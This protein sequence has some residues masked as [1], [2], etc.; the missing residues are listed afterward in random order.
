MAD[1]TNTTTVRTVE[2][3]RYDNPVMIT[4]RVAVAAFLAG[5]TDPTRRSHATDVRIFATEQTHRRC[6]RYRA[7]DSLRRAGT[8][9]VAPR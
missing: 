3:V 6:E 9:R 4:E 1:T 2:V 8:V 5:Y 7:G